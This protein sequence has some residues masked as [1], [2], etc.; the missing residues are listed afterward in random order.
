MIEYK[1]K[2]SEVSI[3]H[4]LNQELFRWQWWFCLFLYLFPLFLWWKIVDKKRL[5]EIMV[6]GL[7]VNII[8]AFLDVMGTNFALWEYSIRILPNIPLFFP[9]DYIDI[10]V[11]YMIIY[12]YFSKWT[13]F[14]IAI[15]IT[16]L[17]FSFVGEP[18]NVWVKMYVLIHW[19]YIYSFPIYVVI[20]IVCKGAINWFMKKDCT[21]SK[22]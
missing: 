9:I 6:F 17:V 8:C 11:T 14:I 5:F 16:A 3:S 18:F 15:T 20:S 10:P 22:K 12:Q 1:S 7:F 19:K 21:D 4:W 13:H 2:Y